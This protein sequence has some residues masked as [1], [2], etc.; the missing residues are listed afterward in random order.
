MS[1]TRPVVKNYSLVPKGLLTLVVNVLALLT[2]W[3]FNH[4][5][6]WGVFHFIFGWIYVLYSLILGRYS[7]GG[8]MEIINNY[9]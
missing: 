5:F 9:I 1:K 8:F 4:S 7:D 2:S 3:F 6:W